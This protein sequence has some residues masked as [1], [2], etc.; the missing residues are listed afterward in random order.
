MKNRIFGGLYVVFGFCVSVLLVGCVKSYNEVSK[1]TTVLIQPIDD[2]EQ[3]LID[4][5]KSAI[6]QV[7][8]IK[9]TNAKE[10]KVPEHAFI[11]V[12]TPRYRADLLIRHLRDS[13]LMS[14]PEVDYMIGIIGHDI[15]TTKYANYQ[16]KIVK[17][18]ASKYQDWG[19]FG[20][21]YRP[22][23]T[24]IVSTYRLGKGTSK[25]NFVLR[26]K[27][28]SCHELGHNFGLPHCPNKN[29]IMQDAAETIKTI[30]NVELNLCKDCR[31]KIGL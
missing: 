7:Y 15:S 26:L 12:K 27:K 20:L 25:E 13:V 22:G 8:G 31:K 11:N 3:D 18:P 29:C 5:V 17:S 28:V 21:G 10:I 14:S 30:D 2:V 23:P 16:Q 6:L 19:I 4:T 9:A 1:G 24:C